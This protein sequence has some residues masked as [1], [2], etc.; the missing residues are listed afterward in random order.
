MKT[1]KKFINRNYK[2]LWIA[3]FT[4]IFL[5]GVG[6]ILQV[7]QPINAFEKACSIVFGIIMITGS[8]FAIL[9]NLFGE[10]KAEEISTWIYGIIMAG[11]AVVFF[12]TI[13]IGGIVGLIKAI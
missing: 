1:I 10:Q 11:L 12:G 2:W 3:L 7:F 6:F 13:I 5:S 9:H 8:G 4:I